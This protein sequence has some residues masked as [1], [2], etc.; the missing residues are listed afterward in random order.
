MY[1]NTNQIKA[2]ARLTTNNVPTTILSNSLGFSVPALNPNPQ[3]V[4]VQHKKLFIRNIEEGAGDS[5]IENLL[6]VFGEF[7]YWKRSK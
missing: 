4:S 7:N 1:S 5:L 2:E 6:A 3:H